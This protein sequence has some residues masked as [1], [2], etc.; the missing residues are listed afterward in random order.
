MRFSEILLIAT[1]VTGGVWLLDTLF[2][3]HKRM[4]NVLSPS[5]NGQFNEPWWL[6]YSKSFFPILL[7]V[8]ILRSF[9]AEPF[10]I[11]SGSM[12]PTLLEG[13][14]I[15]V[16][17]YDYGL[18]VPLS[19]FRLIEI[20][21]PKRGDVIVFKHEENGESID[22]IKRVI[23]LPNDHI[24]YKDKTLYINGEVIKQ[25]FIA[26]KIDTNERGATSP[27]RELREHLDHV[28]HDIYV[29]PAMNHLGS[30]Y[31]YDDVI[32]PQNSYFVMGDNRDNS[33]DSRIWGFVKDQDVQGRAFA[34]W[35]SWDPLGHKVRWDRIFSYI[36]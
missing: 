32:V 27:V 25:D 15:V 26:D 4:M 34:I 20:G 12:H 17:K 13:D 29:Q 28:K 24:Q 18:K 31:Q 10:R 2:F 16:N 22:M 8:F 36:P 5:R 3:R 23:G 19:G 9:L 1:A 11:P 30:Y 21:A 14:F 7:I 35:M 33:K 6:E